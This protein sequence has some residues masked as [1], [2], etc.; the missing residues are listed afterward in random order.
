MLRHLVPGSCLLCDQALAPQL[1]IDLCHF[2]LDSLPWNHPACRRCAH[3]WDGGAAAAEPCDECRERP[4]PFQRAIAPLR[5]QSPVSGW[6]HSLKD[7]LGLV[8]GRVLALLLAD[9]VEAAYGGCAE[10]PD[11]LVPVPLTL[12]RL[13]RRGHNQA[14]TL[15]LPVAR[16]LGLP[17]WRFAVRRAGAGPRQRRLRRS[18]RLTNVRDTF[19]CRV[20]WPPPGPRLAVVDDVLTTGATAA[21][22]SRTLLAAGAAEVHVWCAARTPRLT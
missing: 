2:C 4:P 11:A 16:R 7:E 3:P 12:R 19:T 1:D 9:A 21:A 20:C 6:V 14:L 15:A 17:V 8:S 10:L 22:V 13:A 18:A 5:Y